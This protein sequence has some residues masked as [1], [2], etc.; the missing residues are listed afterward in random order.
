[1]SVWVWPLQVTATLSQVQPLTDV[2]GLSSAT[3]KALL[4]FLKKMWSCGSS[5]FLLPALKLE[6]LNICE[7]LYKAFMGSPVNFCL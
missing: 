1:M 2:L 4:D 7:A 6:A 5:L 3:G